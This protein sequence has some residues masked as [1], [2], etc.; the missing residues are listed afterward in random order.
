MRRRFAREY[1][2][3]PLHLVLFAG[4]VFIT[5]YALARMAD[6]GGVWAF[7]L[8]IVLL[9][10][11]HDVVFAP[12][13]SLLTRLSR[14]AAKPIRPRAFRLLALNHVRVPA[15]LSAILFLLWFPLIV[16]LS[17]RQYE[18][19]TGLE[20]D[21]YAERWLLVSGAL[22]LGSALVY[23]VRRRRAKERA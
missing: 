1:G 4:S 23:V 19:K 9:A 6:V 7:V 11:A 5:A 2:A 14:G 8:L 12:L 17:K 16:G 22:F 3:E 21:V 13:Y 18:S 10:F 20:P 15:A